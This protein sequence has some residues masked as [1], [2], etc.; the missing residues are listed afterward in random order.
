M[1]FADRLRYS[2][3]T[4]S[5]RTRRAIGYVFAG[6]TFSLNLP[7]IPTGAVICQ[8]SDPN[9]VENK[10]YLWPNGTNAGTG[11]PLYNVYF[12]QVENT[13]LMGLTQA[14]K[15]NVESDDSNA[16]FNN[17]EKCPA[18]VIHQSTYGFQPSGPI[19]FDR[20][21]YLR[22]YCNNGTLTTSVIDT[23][24]GALGPKEIP[25]KCNF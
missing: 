9:L 6:N 5:L 16:F 8:S 2:G 17:G 15:F 20:A 7:L 14:L 10:I 23:Q 22:F 1:S 11:L 4:N 3:E 12:N 13:P 24:P 25:I 19:E 21:L 18:G